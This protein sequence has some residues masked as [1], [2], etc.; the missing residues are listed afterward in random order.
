M[1]SKEGAGAA[2]HW[3]GAGVVPA[4]PPPP[5]LHTGGSCIPSPAP[6]DIRATPSLAAASVPGWAGVEDFVRRPGARLF[7]STG[8]QGCTV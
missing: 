1:Q 8:D 2:G 7:G 3:R 4:I 5:W 6:W